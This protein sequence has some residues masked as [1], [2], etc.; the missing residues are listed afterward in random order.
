MPLISKCVSNSTSF[1]LILADNALP[2]FFLAG[3]P[4][5]CDCEMD[6]LQKINQ[7][8][9]AGGSES[10]KYPR[11]MD[12]DSVQCHV[13]NGNAGNGTE[14]SV[15]SLHPDQFLCRYEAHCFAL[16]M[17]CEFF[18]CDCRMQ[19]PK[20]CSCF[21]DST[22]S[23]NVIQCSERGHQDVPPL[24]PMDATSIFLDGNNFTGT[25][26]SQAFIGR[27]RVNSLF[28]NASLIE[29]ISNQTFNGLTELRVLHLENNL[30]KKLQG[31][32]FAN[33]TSLRQLHLQNNRLVQIHPLTF[34]TLSSLR[35]LH[36]E[37]N[38]LLSYPVWNLRVLPD[39]GYVFLAGNAW[40]CQ[41]DFVNRFMEFTRSGVIADSRRLQCYSSD[42][43]TYV[44]LNENVT[45]SD[46]QAVTYHEAG[47][48]V[49]TSSA[50]NGGDI[51]MVPILIGVIAVCTLVVCASVMLFVFRTP[52]RVWLHSKY[53]IRVF[54]ARRPDKLYDAFVSYAV[55]DED[56]VQQVM[57]PQL[58]HDDPGYKLCLQYRDLP[59]S[60]SIADSF[61]GVANLCARHVLVVS[62]S[63]IEAEWP[64][65]KFALQ[66]F[67]KNLRPVVVV[68]EELSSLDLAAA[69]EL[70]LLLKNSVTLRWDEAG[71]WNKLRFYLPDATR[72]PSST[73]NRSRLQPQQPGV[74]SSKYFTASRDWPYDAVI[75]SN[76]SSA[77][78]TRS[79]ILG[80]SPRANEN[81][82]QEQ[83]QQQQAVQLVSNPSSSQ[84]DGSG[85][86]QNHQLQQQW[87]S[88][89]SDS[90]Y[91]WQQSEH[92]YQAVANSEHIY[93]TLDSDGLGGGEQVGVVDVMLPNGQLVAATLVRNPGTGKLV[94]VVQLESVLQH[95][96]QPEERQPL[97]R[98]QVTFPRTVV[99]RPQDQQQQ[100]KGHLV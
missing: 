41:C 78:S 17:C 29:A 91:S 7:M 92:P 77:A 88:D 61:P 65:V 10:N 73:S 68:L 11:V 94:P 21:H 95:Q 79:T 4:F 99:Y 5:V 13:D 96:L 27:K 44:T 22:W 6:W 39:L 14:V 89:R 71:F 69:P 59:S 36:L 28:L 19:C 45:C 86:G 57:V 12:L 43:D 46:A 83:Q 47:T 49:A 3:N 55:K 60:S 40:S 66:D 75:T 76:D 35:E 81:S 84:G 2:E 32:E 37:G 18:A 58:E 82:Q 16:C 56:F 25:L 90:V 34:S 15:T 50:A 100:N 23:A 24:I 26:E 63:Y 9:S 20:G 38:R 98:Q 31:Y 62:K 8:S 54:G 74:P 72:V 33:L 53:G 97:Q 70:N 87:P 85:S 42:Q 1:S 93:H 51:S 52:L 48:G 80:G 67:A 30:M 64:Q